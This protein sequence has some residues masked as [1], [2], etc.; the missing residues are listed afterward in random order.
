MPEQVK[1]SIQETTSLTGVLLRAYWL[2]LA[3]GATAIIALVML[4]QNKQQS[5]A[6]NALL[7]FIFVT[8][9]LVRFIDIRYYKGETGEG[10]KATMNDWKKWSLIITASY[11]VTFVIV[12][13]SGVLFR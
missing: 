11:A 8:V 5:V 9:I 7:L 4:A 6:L 10:Q 1:T 3:H 2:I 12:H 13:I